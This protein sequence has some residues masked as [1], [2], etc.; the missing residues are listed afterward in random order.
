MYCICYTPKYVQYLRYISI[1]AYTVYVY[2]FCSKNKYLLYKKIKIVVAISYKLKE[3]I[4]FYRD[5]L[6]NSTFNVFFQPR[7]EIQPMLFLILNYFSHL[8]C[9][10]CV[11]ARPHVG[12]GFIS[13]PT[14]SS[15]KR[16][17]QN[18]VDGLNTTCVFIS[19]FRN[20]EL[21]VQ[22]YFFNDSKERT[23][24]LRR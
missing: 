18:Q 14:N 11:Y 22:K 20:D 21:V 17:N 10:C 16:L 2:M 24:G 12:V 5:S 6:I 15:F 3:M 9:N 8:M 13:E 7:L 23:P 1:Y 19:Y 4:R